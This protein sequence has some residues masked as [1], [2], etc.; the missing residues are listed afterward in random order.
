MSTLVTATRYNNLQTRIQAVLGTSQ[1][2]A[3]TYGYGQSVDSSQVTGDFATNAGSTNVISEAQYVDIYSDI[4]R[5][6]VHQ[7]GSTAFGTA[8]NPYV[9]GDFNTNG[10]STDKVEEAHITYLEGIMTDCENNRFTMHSSQAAT[11]SLGSSQRTTPW[12]GEVYHEFKLVFPSAAARRHY[13]NAGGEIRIDSTQSGDTSQKGQEW[14]DMITPGDVQ[15]DHSATVHSTGFGSGT[16]IGNYDLTSSY[17]TIWQ[18]T[19]PTYTGNIFYIQA[20]EQSSTEI[21]FKVI[22]DDVNTNALTE[23]DI[24]DGYPDVDEDVSGTLTVQVNAYRPS[25]SV[26]IGSSIT[27]VDVSAPTYT[28]ISGL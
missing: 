5:A 17:Q 22:F 12:N 8:A 25:G 27:T 6:R 10:A 4:V 19:A 23:P 20:K 7:I 11:Q 13:F 26:T 24:S 21:R 1:S 16:T 15:F 2:G 28:S 9:E 18:K 3:T 14:N